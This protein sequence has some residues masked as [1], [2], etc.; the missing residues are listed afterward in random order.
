MSP[1]PESLLGRYGDL[2]LTG[3]GVYVVYAIVLVFMRTFAGVAETA[4]QPLLPDLVPKEQMGT[5]S[6][7]WAMGQMLGN[8]FGAAGTT[9][10]MDQTGPVVITAILSAALGVGA[11]PPPT[12]TLHDFH[13][14]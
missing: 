3:P 8:V 12:A 14:L 5:A 4:F 6:G 13:F 7:W 2:G 10:I 11:P 1:P 9:F